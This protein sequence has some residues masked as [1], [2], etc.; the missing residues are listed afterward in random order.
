M[1]K[2]F[3]CLLVI[4]SF[5]FNMCTFAENVDTDTS[6]SETEVTEPEN[7]NENTDIPETD[8]DKEILPDDEETVIEYDW[9]ADLSVIGENSLNVQSYSV[10]DAEK[11]LMY[12]AQTVLR[13]DNAAG[14]AWIVYEIPYA[15]ELYAVSY[16]LAS[17]VAHFSFETS[18]D[19]EEWTS[20][21]TETTV[22]TDID[23]WT[24]VEYLA[25]DLENIRYI[26]VIWGEEENT[27][28]WWNPYFGGL[29][30]NVGEAHP[31]EIL[32][33]TDQ[34][35]YIPMYDSTE[36]VLEAVILDQAGIE[37]DG[38]ISWEILS[39]DFEI[40]A[41]GEVTVNADMEDGFEF[42]VKASFADGEIT[43][44][45]KFIL[46]AAMP[47][48][49][50]GDNVI[51]KTDI[52]EICTNYGKQATTENRLCDVDKNGLIDIIDLAYAAKYITE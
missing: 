39:E 6:Q 33:L 29:S 50:D 24:K 23:K 28:N 31:T 42:T 38:E 7:S 40:S 41:L 32:I 47:G 37:Y 3:I 14:D 49:T 1:K 17:D 13:R 52:D 51:T 35:L 4:M 15:E 12:D 11:E 19:G 30:T 18:K 16:H 21:E 36:Y 45:K 43:A 22:T 10:E 46:V 27:A 20:I 26:K 34:K 44:E 48:D 2:L 9:Q 8:T 25:K 5:C